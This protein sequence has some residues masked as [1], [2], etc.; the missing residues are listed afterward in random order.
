M[1]PGGRRARRE[2]AGPQ[3]SWFEERLRELLPGHSPVMRHPPPDH[4]S[5]DL[6]DRLAA[7][8]SRS[9]LGPF[10]RRVPLAGYEVDFLFDAQR[11]VVELDGFVHLASPV[12]AK[13]RRKDAALAAMGYRVVHVENQALRVAPD[14]VLGRIRS[15][16]SA[17][18][19]RIAKPLR[20]PRPQ[21][22]QRP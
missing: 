16:L 9:G 14:Q 18:G 17:N 7:L 10:R 22:R 20:R 6:E 2:N 15:A 19:A 5:H 3:G 13:D 1:R 11:L 4:Q 12:Q 8:L 21:G